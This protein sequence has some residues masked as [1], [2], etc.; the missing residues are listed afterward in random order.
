[1]TNVNGIR[2]FSGIMD[3]PQGLDPLDEPKSNWFEIDY[4]EFMGPARSSYPSAFTGGVYPVLFQHLKWKNFYVNSSILPTESQARDKNWSNYIWNK[5]GSP[6]GGNVYDGIKSALNS[7]LVNNGSGVAKLGIIVGLTASGGIGNVPKFVTDRSAWHWIEISNANGHDADH[8]RFD[9]Q[10]VVD[11]GKWAMEAFLEEYGNNTGMHSVQIAEYFQGTQ[12]QLPSGFNKPLYLD[13]MRQ[14]WDWLNTRAPKDSG[15][16]R[17]NL[18]QMLPIF[19][20][21]TNVGDLIAAKFGISISDTYI[22]FPYSNLDILQSV[23]D[24]YNAG[25]LHC[26]LN[27]DS[28][29]SR[30]NRTHSWN[31]AP[32]NPFGHGAGYSSAA[33]PEHLAWYYGSKGVLPVHSFGLARTHGSTPGPQTLPNYRKAI[34]RF[35]RGGSSA[36]Q[37]GPFPVV[38]QGGGVT[39]PTDS[40]PT[41]KPSISGIMSPGNTLGYTHN[42]SDPDG[43]ITVTGQQWER[44]GDLGWNGPNFNL[45]NEHIGE[46]LRIYVDFNDGST[47]Y[48]VP[49]DLSAPIS[50]ATD[51]APTGVATIVGSLVSGNTLTYSH[52]FADEDGP[53]SVTGQQWAIGGV[54]KST[55]PSQALS[56][57]DVGD[58][59]RVRVDFTDGTNQYSE[60]SA[61]SAPVSE[62]TNSPPI[63]SVTVSGTPTP[64]NTLTPSNNLT[65]ADGI[66]GV[67]YSWTRS[68]VSTSH[69]ASYPVTEADRGH[70]LLCKAGYTDGKGNVHTVSASPIFINTSSG[71]SVGAVSINGRAFVGSILTASSSIINFDGGYTF[72]YVWYSNGVRLVS[73]KGS[74]YKTQI[75]DTGAYI[76]VEIEYRTSDG[77]ITTIISQ[78]TKPIK[79]SLEGDKEM[80]D[81]ENWNIT[82]SG[83]NVGAPDGWEEDEMVLRD[84]NDTGREMMAVLARDNKDRDGSLE[85]LGPSGDYDVQLNRSSYDAY[86][87]GMSFTGYVVNSNS[88][89]IVNINVNSIGRTPVLGRDGGSLVAGDVSGFC[90]F[91]YRNGSFY[92]M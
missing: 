45:T 74:T 87:N 33:S 81:I 29:Y 36:S 59:V 43:N 46:R 54:N 77:E 31:N 19:D 62:A 22:Q 69:T 78:P 57:S 37:W 75:S 32:S 88:D 85:I 14:I 17:I 52:N 84:V 9:V 68:G 76:E 30:Q 4:D 56:G 5:S 63:G 44:D 15:G 21:G 23:R 8:A 39:T 12:S 58:K 26:L 91:L 10:A 28:R 6:G 60:W 7:S 2:H 34:D 92:C 82:A 38:M 89:G 73:A 20:S 53:I 61:L 47:S 72:K 1:M 79:Q 13:G 71:P 80:A 64:G 66:N 11:H 49:S 51:R 70:T 16:N 50:G 48:R 35:G 3:R 25:G 83:N 27:G 40:P 42:F 65:D 67:T 24:V 55:G 86:F 18:L 41:G 90:T